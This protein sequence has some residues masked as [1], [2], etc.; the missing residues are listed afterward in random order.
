MRLDIK[1]LSLSKINNS[2]K[3]GFFSFF[4]FFHLIDDVSEPEH[5]DGQLVAG[6]GLLITLRRL[7]KATN[8]CE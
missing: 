5:A 8:K 1:A 7:H 2:K 3:P 6:L 4:S